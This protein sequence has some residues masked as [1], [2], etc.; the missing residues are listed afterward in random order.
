MTDQEVERVRKAARTHA[1][2][3]VLARAAVLSIEEFNLFTRGTRT[4]TRWQLRL[5][6]Q[7]M[8][9]RKPYLRSR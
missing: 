2:P 8:G 4:P 5:L 9:D 7:H 1:H 3:E 6:Q